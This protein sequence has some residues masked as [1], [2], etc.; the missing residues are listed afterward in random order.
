MGPS[1][2]LHTPSDRLQPIPAGLS[3]AER[4]RR[5]RATSEWLAAPLSA[6]DATVQS[7]PDVSPTKWHLAHVTWFF[8]TFLLSAHVEGYEPFEPAYRYLF[9][10]YYNRVGA[11]FPRAQR[12]LITRPGLGDVLRY[13]AYVDEHMLRFLAG[14]PLDPRTRYVVEVGLNHEQQHQELLLMDIKHVLSLNPLAPVYRE[15]PTGAPAGAPADTWIEHEGGEVEIGHPEGAGFAYDNEGPAHRVLLQ[16]F[17]LA[18]RLVTCGAWRA[19]IEDGGYERPDLWLDD[20][21]ATV[22]A[23]GW[24]AP[25]YWRAHDDGW[26]LFTLGGERAVRDEEPVVHISYY[27]A[28]AYATWAGARLPTEAEWETMARRAQGIGS[29]TLLESGALHT[30]PCTEADGDLPHQ[31]VGDVW[32]FTSSAYLPYPGF[33]A[34]DGALGEYNGKFMINQMVLRGGS[35]ATPTDHVRLTYRNFFHPGKRW[36]FGGV[37]LAR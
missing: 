21:W 18:S 3:L 28:D 37:R 12:G 24:Q 35:F 15:I 22:Q 9:N 33:Q 16:P 19:F 14:A 26:R 32:E 30:R 36:Q 6:E 7:M 13:R 34:P 25:L 10:S 8:E 17:A 29:G 23:E 20:G 5:V 11:Q 1:G 4:Y 27:E 2:T 31:M